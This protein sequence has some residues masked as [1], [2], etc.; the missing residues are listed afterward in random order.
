MV[1]IIF[2]IS[3][4][5]HSKFWNFPNIN[6]ETEILLS[7]LSP[8][9]YASTISFTSSFFWLLPKKA[10]PIMIRSAPFLIQ[11]NAL[12]RFSPPSTLSSCFQQQRKPYGSF[13]TATSGNHYRITMLNSG[14]D[15][16]FWKNSNFLFKVRI[17]AHI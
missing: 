11:S 16:L 5:L 1:Y 2:C 17:P 15:F 9:I 14:I 13:R 12:S 7:S 10:R 6:Q 4:H 8:E 3:Y